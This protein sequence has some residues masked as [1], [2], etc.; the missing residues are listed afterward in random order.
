[1]GGGEGG[2]DCESRRGRRSCNV[3]RVRG[4][5]GPDEVRDSDFSSFLASSLI[6]FQ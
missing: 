2:E 3:R 1:M 6:L 4:D 5:S